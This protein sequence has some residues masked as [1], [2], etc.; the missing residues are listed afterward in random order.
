LETELCATGFCGG[1]GV[2]T[3]RPE[4]CDDTVFGFVCGC[5]GLTY[6]SRCFADLAG[7]RLAGTGGGC[8]CE[9]NTECLEGQYCALDDSCTNTGGCLPTPETC[10]PA[11]T[12]EVCGCDGAT[13]ANACTAAQSGARVSALGACECD[14]DEDCASGDYCNAIVCDGPGVCETRNATACDPEAPVEGCCDPDRPVT[15]CDGIIY[16]SECDAISAGVR[17]RP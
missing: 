17:V 14:T 8:V 16:P 15:G 13:Y 11:D 9:D 12:Q 4:S 10:D 2:C 3:A 5:D 1:I 7:V 6:Q